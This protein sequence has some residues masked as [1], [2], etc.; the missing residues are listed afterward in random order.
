MQGTSEGRRSL[1]IALSAD[2]MR[3][4]H[5]HLVNIGHR[6]ETRV[7]LVMVMHQ[8]HYDQR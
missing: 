1:G 3:G 8:H 2:L 6:R 4:D 7:S 5:P